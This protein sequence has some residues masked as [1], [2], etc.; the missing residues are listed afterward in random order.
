M[1]EQGRVLAAAAGLASFCGGLFRDLQE[2]VQPHHAHRVCQSRQDRVACK[3]LSAF[4]IVL[5]R[6]PSLRCH[7]AV[8][9]HMEL[10]Q[11][12]HRKFWVLYG[13]AL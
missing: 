3:R 8:L 7:S 11:R 4:T 2:A 1:T 9:D 12:W 10:Q 5:R 6:P 13:Y